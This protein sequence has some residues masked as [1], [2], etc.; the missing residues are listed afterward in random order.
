M[1]APAR[2]P[3]NENDQYRV[4]RLAHHARLAAA[5]L[6]AADLKPEPAAVAT[7]VQALVIEAALSEAVSERSSSF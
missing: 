7:L 2:T 6:R 4:E 5:A 1:T 3:F